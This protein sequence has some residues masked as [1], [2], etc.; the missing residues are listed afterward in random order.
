MLKEPRDTCGLAYSMW[1]S[2]VTDTVGDSK[3][4]TSRESDSETGNFPH[5]RLHIATLPSLP[6]KSI[7]HHTSCLDYRRMC[8][9]S[10]QPLQHTNNSVLK[11]QVSCTKYWQKF[12]QNWWEITEGSWS[13]SVQLNHKRWNACSMA[14]KRATDLYTSDNSCWWYSCE[15][16]QIIQR[17]LTC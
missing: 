13:E 8:R 12:P 4:V 14:P 1:T 17:N 5:V 15:T 3:Q 9:G 11:Q 7:H 2:R 16:P 6:F 10:N